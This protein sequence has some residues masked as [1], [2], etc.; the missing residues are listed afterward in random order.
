[1]SRTEVLAVMG[2]ETTRYCQLIQGCPF[3]IFGIG[4]WE[5]VT[6]PYRN[7]TVRSAAGTSVEVLY[8]Y[9]D[10]KHADGSITDDEL[11]PIVLEEGRVVGWGW[12]FVDQAVERY[13]IRI[14]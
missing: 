8:Y 13:E 12:S 10:V 7:E 1:M 6:N 9:T 3:G 4:L 11:T 5:S 2:T 14:R